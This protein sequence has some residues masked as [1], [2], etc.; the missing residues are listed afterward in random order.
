MSCLFCRIDAGEVPATIVHETKTT[1]AFRDDVELKLLREF[2]STHE[3]VL[4]PGD[5]RRLLALG[6]EAFPDGATG[7]HTILVDVT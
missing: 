5:V 6:P 3:W 2:H 1:L 4:A 7:H